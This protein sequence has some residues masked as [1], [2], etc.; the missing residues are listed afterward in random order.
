MPNYFF[1][2]ARIIKGFFKLVLW[3]ILAAIITVFL[4]WFI[5]QFHPVFDIGIGPAVMKIVNYLRS[6]TGI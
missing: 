5:G 3:L 4:L 2:L 1:F 6:I